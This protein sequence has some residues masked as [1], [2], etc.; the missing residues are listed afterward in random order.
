M[1][2]SGDSSERAG[3]KK[4]DIGVQCNIETNLSDL[5][6]DLFFSKTGNYWFE[7]RTETS[8]NTQCKETSWIWSGIGGSSN[9]KAKNKFKLLKVQE[10][11]D[12]LIAKVSG[13]EKSNEEVDECIED[14]ICQGNCEHVG[15][16]MASL[17]TS[18]WWSKTEEWGLPQC[19]KLFKLSG[20]DV[21]SVISLLARIMN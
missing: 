17:K 19:N 2:Q 8:L 1:E 6:Q 13:L 20:F 4:E 7:E 11:K 18:T 10:E 15:C 14:A 3:D 5:K 21:P 16:S 9:W 12:L